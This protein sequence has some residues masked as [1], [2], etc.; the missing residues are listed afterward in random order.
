MST[1]LEK[2]NVEDPYTVLMMIERTSLRE[3]TA[4]APYMC[5]LIGKKV[6]KYENDKNNILHLSWTMHDWLD[7][8]NRKRRLGGQKSLPSIILT[9]AG[10]EVAERMTLRDGSEV[11][12]TKV[13]I[14]IS[15]LNAKL[16]GDLESMLKAGSYR[17]DDGSWITFVNVLNLDTFKHCLEWKA[18]QTQT[19]WS[20]NGVSTE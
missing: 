19:L 7:G 3:F 9:L 17:D 2:S 10:N 20:E 18:R 1:T 13:W 16:L 8:L 11:N 4:S 5:H 12:T 15:S 6:K 14:K